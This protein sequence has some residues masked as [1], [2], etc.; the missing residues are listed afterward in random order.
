MKI[1]FAVLKIY[2]KW[3]IF[4]IA[5]LFIVNTFQRNWSTVLTVTFNNQS[6]Y[7]LIIAFLVTFFSH[8]W[9][10]LVWV[11]ILNLLKQPMT[12]KWGLKVYLTTNIFKYVPGNIGHFYGR[13]FAIHKQGISFKIASFTVLLEPLFMA[14]SALII[15]LSSYIVG[16]NKTAFNPWLFIIQMII[17]L[18]GL[19][20]I[21][22]FF[23][24]RIFFYFKKINQD[25]IQNNIY[26]K[27]YPKTILLGEIVFILLRA[28]GFI[29]TW[30]AFIPIS[31][32]QIPLLLNTFSFAWL[33]GLIIPG[34]PSG[35]GVFEATIIFLLK[36]ENFPIQIV[37]STIVIFRLISILAEVAGAGLW[38]LTK[39]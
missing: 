4:G 14:N 32:I 37:L 30:I 12:K 26:L 9:S 28:L 25:S 16:V 11:K 33:L 5:L 3:F 15:T 36:T 8:I 31:I 23:I 1:A 17:M 10:A 29:L 18:I 13:I 34:A 27:H 20:A 22:P 39:E 38:L 2:L 35:I 24:N 6:Y 19:L 21:H 7:L